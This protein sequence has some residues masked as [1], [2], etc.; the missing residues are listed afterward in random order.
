[1]SNGDEPAL[2]GR[3]AVLGAGLGAAG[4]TV[5]DTVRGMSP[6]ITGDRP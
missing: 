3:L 4:D 5:E 1:M 6:D 2:D